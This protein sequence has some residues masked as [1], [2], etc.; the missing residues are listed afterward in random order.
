MHYFYSKPSK[1]SLPYSKVGIPPLLKGCEISR[2]A[3]AQEPLHVVLLAEKCLDA[4]APIKLPVAH[5][6][7]CSLAS[8][9]KTFLWGDCPLLRHISGKFLRAVQI[10]NFQI[11]C[12]LILQ[13]R[14]NAILALPDR[15]I[16]RSARKNNN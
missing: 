10:I 12:N 11:K 1:I 6:S 4:P 16:S 2:A 14:F 3:T 7:I 15:V 9:L 8:R 5:R 13:H